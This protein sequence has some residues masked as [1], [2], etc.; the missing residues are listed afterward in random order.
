MV[1][2]DIFIKWLGKLKF[3]CGNVNTFAYKQVLGYYK[4]VID[5]FRSKSFQQDGAIAHSSKGFQNE[6]IHY[7]KERFIPIWENGPL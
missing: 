7:F 5:T 6:I 2:V 1:S 4:D 3:H